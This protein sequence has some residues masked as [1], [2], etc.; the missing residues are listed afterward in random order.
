M[1][2]L[3]TVILG[4]SA[5]DHSRDRVTRK[6]EQQSKFSTDDL[7]RKKFPTKVSGDVDSDPCK[8]GKNDF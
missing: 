5:V 8:S 7:L 4:V 1:L 6:H 3:V 2:W